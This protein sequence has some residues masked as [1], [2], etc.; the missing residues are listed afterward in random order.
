MRKC[1]F[2]TYG[3]KGI[4]NHCCSFVNVCKN[5]RCRH[6]NIR[7]KWEG[8]ARFQKIKYHCGFIQVAKNT[9]RKQCCSWR[10]TSECKRKRL[11]KKKM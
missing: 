1:T 10:I 7:C 2:R 3:R 11:S 9:I 8:C 4:R 6:K 5:N